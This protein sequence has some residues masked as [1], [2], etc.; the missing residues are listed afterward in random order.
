MEEKGNLVHFIS[1]LPPQLLNLCREEEVKTWGAS[2]SM[3]RFHGAQ[4]HGP[5]P[6]WQSQQKPPSPLFAPP[7]PAILQLPYLPGALSQSLGILGVTQ[8]GP[9][10]WLLHWSV[11]GEFYKAAVDLRLSYQ[12]GVCF[13]STSFIK[14]M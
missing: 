14:C 2:Y 7:L 8:S 10:L 12:S 1:L 13:F 11:L 9:I 4:M 5:S 3:C 6:P